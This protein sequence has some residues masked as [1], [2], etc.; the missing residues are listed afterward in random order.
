[1]YCWHSLSTWNLQKPLGTHNIPMETYLIT[2]LCLAE[3]T[4][5]LPSFCFISS[6]DL[7]RPVFKCPWTFRSTAFNQYSLKHDYLQNVQWG[8]EENLL[9]WEPYHFS[10]YI[11]CIMTDIIIFEHIFS[12]NVLYVLYKRFTWRLLLWN[13]EMYIWNLNEQSTSLQQPIKMPSSPQLYPTLCYD[14]KVSGKT[15]EQ[16]KL[17]HHTLKWEGSTSI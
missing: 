15:T 10:F 8:R 5:L 6:R 3:I 12:P 2:W 1:M 17:P 14:N 13:A 9:T 7:P 11:L 4:I 16:T